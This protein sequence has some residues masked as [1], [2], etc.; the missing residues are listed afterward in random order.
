MFSSYRPKNDNTEIKLHLHMKSGGQIDG[1]SPVVWWY[2]EGNCEVVGTSVEAA[3]ELGAESVDFAPVMPLRCSYLQ[4][5]EM[6]C[7][8]RLLSIFLLTCSLN[9]C[10]PAGVGNSHAT[11]SPEKEP[12]LPTCYHTGCAPKRIR[13]EEESSCRE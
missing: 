3:P 8:C 5:A 13:S 4:Y 9:I 10:S 2:R 11:S 7:Y 12:T 1:Q 6:H